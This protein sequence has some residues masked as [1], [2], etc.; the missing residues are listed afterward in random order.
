M[1]EEKGGLSNTEPN[2]HTSVSVVASYSFLMNSSTSSSS[3]AATTTTQTRKATDDSR[4]PPLPLDS[5]TDVVQQSSI[6]DA[7]LSPCSRMERIPLSL[8][9]HDPS[10]LFYD[11]ESGHLYCVN[12]D[13]NLMAVIVPTPNSSHTITLQNQVSTAEE[14]DLEGITGGIKRR[15]NL[16]Y[17]VSEYP[18]T[19]LEVVGETGVIQNRWLLQEILDTVSLFQGENDFEVLKHGQFGL[20]SILYL[21]VPDIF[22]VGRQKDAKLFVFQLRDTVEM[23]FL[24]TI[25]P[26][27]PNKDLSAM[28]LHQTSIWL[29][30]DKA[31]T[32]L[33]FNLQHLYTQLDQ[34]LRS[35]AVSNLNSTTTLTP[36]H[37]NMQNHLA[38]TD[39]G[40][41][42]LDR[43]GAEGIAFVPKATSSSSLR[44][45]WV[46][47]AFDPPKRKKNSEKF[48]GRMDLNDFL[49]CYHR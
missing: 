29:L 20:E 19:I 30:Y 25:Q 47:L 14:F 33:Y 2:L 28:T 42:Q 43:R 39:V 9:F 44:D 23:F 27:G 41:L 21:P 6:N 46:Y 12:D 49:V 45:Y 17:L 8:S 37:I 38:A 31:K 7:S 22:L 32:A 16:V 4:L 13:H 11:T 35:A 15:P 18:S 40:V 24:G 5:L 48:L 10:D 34:M 26:P 1:R 36:L 3:S